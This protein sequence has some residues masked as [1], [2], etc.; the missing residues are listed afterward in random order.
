MT[1]F[2]VFFFPMVAFNSTLVVLFVAFYPFYLVSSMASI[3]SDDDRANISAATLGTS[4]GVSA[5]TVFVTFSCF[6][7]R[8]TSMQYV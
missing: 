5:L 6:L 4:S 3:G 2:F 1:G 8:I 7:R